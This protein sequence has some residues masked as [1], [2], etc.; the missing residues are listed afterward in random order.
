MFL[1]LYSKLHMN[2]VQTTEP[3]QPIKFVKKYSKLFSEAVRGMKLKL[4]EMFI[5]L[6]SKK[7]CFFFVFFFFVF[8][9]LLMCFRCNG[10]LSFHKL[11]MGKMK[12]GLFYYLI[13]DILTKVFTEIVLE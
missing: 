4:Q 9:P 10:N 8:L 6:A 13:G 2:F 11:I 12:V 7:L 5:T 3:W 1:E